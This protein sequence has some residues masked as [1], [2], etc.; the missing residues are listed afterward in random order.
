MNGKGKRCPVCGGACRY[1]V[2]FDDYKCR[3][4]GDAF[5]QFYIVQHEAIQEQA[6]HESKETQ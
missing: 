3:K 1:R 4:C 5:S 2:T 6:A